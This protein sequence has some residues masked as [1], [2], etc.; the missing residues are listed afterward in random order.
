MIADDCNPS[1]LMR[2][3]GHSSIQMTYDIYGYLMKDEDRDRSKVERLAK[4]ILE[5]APE[6]HPNGK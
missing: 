4:T 1:Y 6:T 3:L 2:M 5:N